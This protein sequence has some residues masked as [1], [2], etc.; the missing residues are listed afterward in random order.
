MTAHAAN[1]EEGEHQFVY[2]FNVVSFIKLLTS[3]SIF[4][5]LELIN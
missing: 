4:M 1:L 5:K 2:G 3:I